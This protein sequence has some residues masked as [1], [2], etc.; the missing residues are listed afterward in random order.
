MSTVSNNVIQ[1]YSANNAKNIIADQVYPAE[2][3]GVKF[4]NYSSNFDY[5]TTNAKQGYYLGNN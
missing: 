4:Y 3:K 1:D 5:I 2:S